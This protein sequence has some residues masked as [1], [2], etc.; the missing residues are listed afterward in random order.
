MS[1]ADH[2]WLAAVILVAF[3]LRVHGLADLPFPWADETA[4]VLAASSYWSSGQLGP[5]YWEH[6][7]L[8]HLLL[9]GFQ[10]LL[11][12]GAWGARLRNVLFGTLAAALTFLLARRV[13]GDRRAAALAGLLLAT[14][15]LHVVMSRF[16]W[17]E[18]YGGAFFLG[19]LL[20]W[21]THAGRSHRLALA[22]LL[23]GCALA[24]KWYYV[25]CWLAV[26]PVTLWQE[27]RWRRPGA[28][29]LVTCTWL[30]LPLGVYVLAYLPWFGRGYGLGELLE[31]T[32][33]AYHSLQAI[34][35][36]GFDV[37]TVFLAHTSAL[38]WFTGLVVVGEG[39]LTGQGRGVFLL[40][41]NG[42]PI[43]TLTLP[44][45]AGLAGLAWRRRRPELALPAFVLLSSWALFLVV[46]RPAFVYSGAPLLPFAFTAI[47]T[48][49]VLL[50]DRVSPR[51]WVALVVLAVAWNGFLYPLV[52]A[53]EVP[54]APYRFLV[55]A[56][57]V[58]TR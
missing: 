55:D 34:S 1:R 30:L 9:H 21:V 38:E 3:G 39:Q 12:E 42:W 47:A 29:A 19:A 56:P 32:A 27:G 28:V 10:A 41:L 5:D 57:G 52:T 26:W 14:D 23:M 46:D 40:Y 36:Q 4:H 15:P 13:S 49:L 51:A 17:E 58:R 45:L 50:A 22:A 8:R 24:T 53:R 25:P 31:V 16:T 48:A 7:P 54:L 37:E 20:A 44:A 11:G 18:I 33:N 35:P 43:W 6:P 2:A